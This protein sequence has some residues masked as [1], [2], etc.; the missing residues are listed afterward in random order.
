M[1]QESPRGRPY[2]DKIKEG[3]E[4]LKEQI[5]NSLDVILSDRKKL[6]PILIFTLIGLLAFIR[7]LYVVLFG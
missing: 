4:V 7:G 5:K 2:K 3:R 1:K 6:L